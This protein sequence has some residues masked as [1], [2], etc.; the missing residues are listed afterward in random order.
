MKFLFSNEAKLL[1]L[2]FLTWQ[3][4]LL[5]TTAIAP[6]IIP[7]FHQSFPY[8]NDA[9]LSWGLP[10]II[11]PF[12]NFD[13]VHYVRLARDGYISQFT[14]AFFPLYPLL[15]KIL[16]KLTFGNLIIA[17]IV[18]SNTSFLI[19]ILVFYK[20]LLRYFNEK[21][22]YWSCLFLIFFPTSFFFA[23]V[24]T[25]SLFF[26]LLVLSFFFA[27]QK[28]YLIASVFGAFA[29]AT[30]LVGVLL[31]IS[32]VKKRNILP[33]LIIPLGLIIYMIFLKFTINDPLAFI[34]SQEAFG[35]NRSTSHLIF[36]P[37]VFY[38]YL[39]ILVTARGTSLFSAMLEL[40]SIIGVIIALL[41]AFIKKMPRE[42]LI[43]ST[44]SVL[45]PTLTGTFISMPRYILIAFPLFVVLGSIEKTWIKLTIL[46][47]FITL[48]LLLTVMF[49]RGYWVA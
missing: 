16:S 34:S 11:W 35:Q 6:I 26:L 18:I 25:E 27:S 33:L 22:A 7:I 42:W 47:G 41:F 43:F 32:L 1:L 28:K 10:N 30:K 46:S 5:W 15:V 29:S 36:L 13:G 20:L 3:L 12:A 45:L 19:S 49:T 31:A 48:L 40:I 4:I 2:F 23:A 9:I 38:R 8:L 39:K 44:L 21:I 17:G 24:Y 14:Q 37:Q